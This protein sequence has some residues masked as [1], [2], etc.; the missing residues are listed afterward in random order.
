MGTGKGT[1]LLLAREKTNGKLS[2]N[3]IFFL[4]FSCKRI[5]PYRAA[6]RSNKNLLPLAKI[7]FLEGLNGVMAFTAIG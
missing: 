7:R 5:L 4:S 3:P 2:V 6:L 1:F